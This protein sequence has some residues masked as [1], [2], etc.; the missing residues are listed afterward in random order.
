MDFE[1]RECRYE[2]AAPALRVGIVSEADVIGARVRVTFP[3]YDHLLSYWLPIVVPKTQNDKAYWIPDIGEQ[4]ICLM[5]LRD[6]AGVVLG[7]IYSS[8]D[9]APVF[10]ADKWHLGFR[11]GAAFEYDRALHV[12]S[13]V[14]SDASAIN[15]NAILHVMTSAYDDGANFR[16]DAGAHRM[17]LAFNDGAS[18]V[19]DAGAHALTISFNDGASFKYDASAHALTVASAGSVKIT[20]S[21][22]TTIE[23]NSAGITLVS[24]SSQVVVSPQGVSVVP[25]LP[26]SSTV[27][28]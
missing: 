25:P 27:A 16:Y 20:S 13:L 14:F 17:T 10:S 26:L 12:L 21:T 23:D 9:L 22:G 28:Q 8:A 1:N 2:R 6:E 3:D 7:A 19:Y 11:D 24:G 5:D 18:I 4:V 15:Y